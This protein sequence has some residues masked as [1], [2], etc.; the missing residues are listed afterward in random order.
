MP[1][2]HA[3]DV[4]VEYRLA[5]AERERE[6]R[7]RGRAADAGQRRHAFEIG[8]KPPAMLITDDPGGAVK[9]SARA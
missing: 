2:E 4:A 6:D 5:L 3:P 7:A 9:V 1:R 8:R